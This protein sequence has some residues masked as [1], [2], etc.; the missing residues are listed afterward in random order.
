MIDCHC[1]L[2]QKDYNP[3]REKVIAECKQKL[4]A[5][6]TCCAHPSDWNLTKEIAEKHKGFI[7]GIAGIHPEFI[8]EI[9]EKEIEEFLK[10]IKQEAK[11]KTIVGIGETGLDFHWIKEEEWREKQKEMFRKFI[12]LA[13]E[14]N[15]PLVVHSRDAVS[16]CIEILEGEEMQNKKI[17]MHLI[18][19]K[20]FVKKVVENGWS[21]SIGPG[22]LKSKETG[23]IA[24]DVPLQNLML[25]TDSPWFGFGQR[26]TPL[27]VFK[28]AEKIA[29]IKKIS[30]EEIEKQTDLNAKKFFGIK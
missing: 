1:H 27:N 11:A 28:A 10:I 16:E 9:S 30:V 20:S 19:N 5:V 13:K 15:L 14:F 22:I 17:L 21:I 12:A 29:D 18:G 25:E 6:V 8:K 3:D 24:R 2:E 7:Y 26:G 4:K 23:K